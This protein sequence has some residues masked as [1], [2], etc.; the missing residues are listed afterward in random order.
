MPEQVI[1]SVT[2][3]FTPGPIVDLIH[4]RG[5]GSDKRTRESIAYALREA[6]DI[7]ELPDAEVTFL[8]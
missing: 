2:I 1:F 3:G 7:I 8:S 6:A 5:A 4:V